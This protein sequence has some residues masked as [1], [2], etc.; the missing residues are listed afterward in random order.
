MNAAEFQTASCAVLGTT[1]G[2]QT[3]IAHQLGVTSRQ[4][5]RWIAA[6]AVPAWAEAK[7]LELMG[8]TDHSPFPRD[9][10]VVGQAVTADGRPRDYVVHLVHPRFS[11][12]IVMVDDDGAP[13]PDDEPADVATGIVYQA[14]PESVLCEIDWVD[15]P[16]AGEITALMEAAAEAIEVLNERAE[17][18]SERAETIRCGD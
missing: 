4:V 3:K 7:L 15:E 9:E 11:A 10:W 13:D 2:W 16:K 12:R 1:I 5:R 17:R 14:D 8:G 6:D 18:I